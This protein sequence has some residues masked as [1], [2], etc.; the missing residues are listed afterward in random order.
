M[1]VLMFSQDPQALVEGSDTFM[2]M[3]D[4]AEAFGE[5]HVIVRAARA[6]RAPASGGLFMYPVVA[7]GILGFLRVW[8]IGVMLCRKR[9]FDV[10]SVQA[11]DILG[12][13]SFFLSRRFRIPLQIQLHTDYMSPWYRR[14]SWKERAQYHLARFLIPRAD[15]VRVVSE[16]IRRSLLPFQTTSGTYSR[17]SLELKRRITILP[18][19][20]DVSRFLN[21]APDAETEKRFAQYDFKMIAVGRFLDKEK[22]FSMLIDVMRLFVRICPQALLVVVGEGPDNRK[23]ESGIRNYG[24]TKN[25]I[26]EPWRSD[27]PSF[28]KSFDLFLLSSNYEGWGRAVIEAMAAGLPVVMTDVGLAGEVVKNNKNG[29]V[30]PVGDAQAFLQAIQT[31]YKDPQ[32]RNQFADAGL[33]TAKNLKPRT[34][35]EYLVRYREYLEFC[36]VEPDEKA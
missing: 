10:I 25:I 34:R 24:L 15:C 1:K 12:S 14:A 32:K 6:G 30:V 9:R 35:A 31:L 29:I 28:L 36:R 5:L 19:F 16:R 3:R 11:P 26:I 21:A 23:Y 27:L 4:Y 22:N 13:I 7:R 17:L 33:K 2:R 20:T 8:R 18:I